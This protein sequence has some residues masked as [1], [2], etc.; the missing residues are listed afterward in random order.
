[1][2]TRARFIGIDVSAKRGCAIAALDC[3]GHLLGACS[4]IG[5]PAAVTEAIEDLRDGD[6]LTIGIDAPRRLLMRPRDW[7]WRG[8]TWRKRENQKGWGRHC[9]VVI[10]ALDLANPQWTP[11][12]DEASEWMRLG[13]Q[14]FAA[15]DHCGTVHEV[16]PSATYKQLNCPDKPKVCLSFRRFHAAGPK[17]MLDAVA[18]ALTVAEYAAGRGVEVGGG[19]GLG[20]IVLPRGIA[21]GESSKKVLN[22]PP[23]GSP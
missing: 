19:D 17:D 8:G 22:W 4:A 21:P 18:G 16:F 11:I 23:P 12:T 10:K 13:V 2:A 1:M 20:S 6:E 3:A 5:K 9:E 14:L 15:L 7:Y